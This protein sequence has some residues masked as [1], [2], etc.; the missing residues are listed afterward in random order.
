MVYGDSGMNFRYL[1]GPSRLRPMIW[2]PTPITIVVYGDKPRSSNIP[3]SGENA[4]YVRPSKLN[5]IP[6]S[7]LSKS[8]VSL[9]NGSKVGRNHAIDISESIKMIKGIDIAA[10]EKSLRYVVLAGLICISPPSKD[11]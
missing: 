3:K 5:M 7:V 9:K 2:Q 4:A 8:K 11:W 1:A 10:V 6:D